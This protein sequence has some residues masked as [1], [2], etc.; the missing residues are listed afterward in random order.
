[1]NAP[2]TFARRWNYYSAVSDCDECPVCGFDGYLPGYDCLVCQ[3]V[4]ELPDHLLTDS[5]AEKLAQAVKAA[6]KAAREGSAR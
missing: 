2:T 3:T 6:V 4:D 5:T 1:M